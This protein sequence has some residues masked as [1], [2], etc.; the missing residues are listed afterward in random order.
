MLDCSTCVFFKPWLNY[1]LYC[2]T[3]AALAE[4]RDN[5]DWQKRVLVK[6]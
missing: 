6:R 5:P 2:R 1:G 3:K 4:Q